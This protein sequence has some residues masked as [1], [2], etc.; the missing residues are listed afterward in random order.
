MSRFY[1]AVALARMSALQARLLLDDGLKSEAL[2]LAIRALALV[3]LAHEEPRL[4]PV[5]IRVA[6]R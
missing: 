6:R 1:Q 3:W 4:Q 5:R 2:E